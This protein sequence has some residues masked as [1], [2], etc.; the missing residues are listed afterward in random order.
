MQWGPVKRRILD[1]RPLVPSVPPVSHL[2]SDM[3]SWRVLLVLWVLLIPVLSVIARG[4]FY[5][6][7]RHQ[8]RIRGGVILTNYTTTLISV[9]TT[10]TSSTERATVTSPSSTRSSSTPTS[11]NEIPTNSTISVT[12]ETSSTSPALPS[13]TEPS[14]DLQ[15]VYDRRVEAIISGLTGLGSIRTW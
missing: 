13:P 7:R 5:D 12:S 8:H 11:V 3:P 9:T 15:N 10:P 6:S 14:S 4:G 2:F 1:S